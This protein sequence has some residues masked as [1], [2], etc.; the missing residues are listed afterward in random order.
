MVRR[1]VE[2][3][4][5]KQDEV[6]LWGTGKPFREFLHVD[7]LADAVYLLMQNYSDPEI[8]NVGYGSDITIRNLA[9]KIADAAGFRG[10][11]GWDTSKPDGMFRKLMDSSKMQKLGWKPTISLDE[12]I[13]RAVAEYRM[14]VP[15]SDT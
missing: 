4:R 12:G 13:K 5:E 11:I 2:A 15:R 10:T 8:I 14:T 9:E 7:D 1:F 6:V 3:V